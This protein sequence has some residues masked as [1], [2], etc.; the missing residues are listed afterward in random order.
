[1]REMRSVDAEIR[2]EGMATFTRIQHT[3]TKGKSLRLEP[4]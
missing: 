2:E 4:A 1:M 3:N